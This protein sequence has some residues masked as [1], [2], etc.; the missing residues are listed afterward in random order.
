[1]TGGNGDV[2]P[3]TSARGLIKQIDALT[4]DNTVGFGMRRAKPYPGK[5]GLTLLNEQ[6][7]ES[8]KI[9]AHRLTTAFEINI[10]SSNC[11]GIAQLVEQA[12][13][14]RWVTGSS[15]VAG[16]SPPME[17]FVGV[18]CLCCVCDV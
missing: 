14:N 18:I 13:V 4:L 3:A 5:Y 2:M 9:H 16:A 7:K 1:M 10:F 12:A 8:S 17:S 11:S 15:P 6:E